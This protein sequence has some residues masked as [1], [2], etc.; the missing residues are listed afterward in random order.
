M[1]NYEKPLIPTNGHDVTSA[2]S[3]SFCHFAYWNKG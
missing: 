2:T 1:R 3:S